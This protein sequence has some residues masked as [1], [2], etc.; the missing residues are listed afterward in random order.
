MLLTAIVLISSAL[1]LYTCGVWSERRAGTLRTSHL[2]LFGLG[3]TADASGTFVMSRIAASSTP[4]SAGTAGILTQVMAV[5][6]AAALVLMAA[7]LTWAAIVLLRN[8]PAERL[9][10]HRLS[11][12]VWA[13]WLVPYFTGMVGS[14][15]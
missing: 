14:M 6:G 3:L 10:F 1:V 15:V 2:A 5:T 9:A 4:T 7:H 13:I 12:I 11:L 8:R